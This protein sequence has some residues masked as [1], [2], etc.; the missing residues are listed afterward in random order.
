V[1]YGIL[2]EEDIGKLFIAGVLPGILLIG[3]FLAAVAVQMAIDPGKGPPGEASTWPQRLHALSGIWGVVLLFTVI[4]GGIYLGIFTPT[5]A[6]GIG[7]A[8]A[9]L[10]ATLRG[11]LGINGTFEALIESSITTG[12]IFIVTFGALVFSNFVN[13]AGFTDAMVAWIASLHASPLGVVLAICVIYIILGCVF[14]SLAMLIL[15]VPVFTAILKPMGV[16][17]IWFGIVVIIVIELG[18]ITPPIGMNVFVVNAAIPDVDIWTVFRGIGPFIVAML[19]CL[20]L[21]IAFPS[22]ATL[23]PRLM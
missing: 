9:F 19:I 18:L 13:I 3:L 23:L 4:I 6:A 2:A 11:K 5:E 8:S 1:I 16:D 12:M 22:I 14:D 15:T 21:V 7:A 20:A 17:L 10:L